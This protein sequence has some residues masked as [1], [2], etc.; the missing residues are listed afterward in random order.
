MSPRNRPTCHM[1]FNIKMD[2]TWKARFVAGS[3]I[4]DPPASITYSSVVAHD[5]VHLAFL[6]AALSDFDILSV[7]IG[8][9]YL[10]APTKKK[11]HTTC[12]MEFGHNYL[13]CIAIIKR[14]LYGLKSSGAAWHNMFAGTL[15]D[16][17]K[18]S[19][20]NPDVWLRPATKMNGTL[21]MNTY[22][23]MWMTFWWSLSTL[24]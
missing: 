20:T 22:L 4:T 8:N 1:I 2:F 23:S 24:S 13:G 7:D 15:Q 3:H 17:Y 6:I 21:I 14:A 11:V 16:Q 19:L 5:S 12:S 9:A 18:S 10:N